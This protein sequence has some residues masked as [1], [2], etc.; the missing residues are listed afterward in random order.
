MNTATGP[1]STVLV[2][3]DNDAV[4]SS[5]RY[6][7][8]R[9]GY[10]C[11]L[12]GDGPRALELA[13]RERPSLVLLDVML[14][15]IDGLEVCRRIRAESNVPIIM[16]TARVDEV[17]RVVGLEVGADDY[18]TKPFSMAELLSR[19]RALLRRRELDRAEAGPMVLRV[20]ALVVDL[21]RHE[22]RVDDRAVP[23][24]P[25]E[26]KLVSLLASAPERAFSRREIVQH[27]WDSEYA[28]DMRACDTHI[29]NLRRK[30]ERDPAHPERL[31]TV[32]GV[33]YR[34]VPV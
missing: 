18:V 13:R 2:V 9:D 34:L 20:G 5:L 11:L 31:V 17:D 22:L 8:E 33:G 16:L 21:V 26:F 6:N 15:G 28:G 30:I 29:V 4:S 24:T 32:R 23:L 14:P 1:R 12:A 27:L 25:S 19:I 10:S 7:L 3:E